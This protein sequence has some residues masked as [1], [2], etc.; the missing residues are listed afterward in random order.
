ME[1]KTS[2]QE[3]CTKYAKEKLCSASHEHDWSL[4]GNLTF[5]LK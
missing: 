3:L 2:N 4:C 1:E 5:Y